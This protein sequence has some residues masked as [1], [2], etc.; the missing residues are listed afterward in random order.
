MSFDLAIIGGGA[1]GL[2]AAIEAKR[3][4]KKAGIDLNV[5]VF[6]HLN[7][8]AKKI[9]ATGNGRCNFCN[10]D[11][12]ESHYFGDNDFI[13]DVLSSKYNDSIGFFKSMGI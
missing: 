13:K 10:T 7:K 11:L 8:P 12:N 6:E 2:S 5:T 3:E 4:S 9:L 1:S